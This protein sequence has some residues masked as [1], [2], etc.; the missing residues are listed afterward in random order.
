MDTACPVCLKNLRECQGKEKPAVETQPPTEPVAEKPKN[1]GGKGT[2]FLLIVAMVLVE[3]IGYCMKIQRPK[4]AQVEEDFEDD[5]YGEGYES[6]EIYK[7]EARNRKVS[8]FSFTFLE[9]R[10][11]MVHGWGVFL[12]ARNRMAL[13][14]INTFSARARQRSGEKSRSPFLRILSGKGKSLRFVVADYPGLP[15][16]ILHRKP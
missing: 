5:D 14:N 13:R 8:G 4:Q 1:S 9:P 11:K 10:E 15:A 2:I 16:A 3:S 12:L 6:D 7:G